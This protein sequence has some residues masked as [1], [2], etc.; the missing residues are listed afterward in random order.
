MQRGYNR[1]VSAGE[2][3]DM[4][5]AQIMEGAPRPG[6]A[7]HFDRS[8]PDP[9]EVHGIDNH[10]YVL[11]SFAKNEGLSNP[12]RG[13]YAFQLSEHGY[14]AFRGGAAADPARN[15]IGDRTTI[16]AVT[17]AQ[18]FNFYIPDPPDINLA[19]LAPAIGPFDAV[20]NNPLPGTVSATPFAERVVLRW[21]ETGRQA[22]H[23]GPAPHQFEFDRTAAPPLSLLTPVDK[24]DQFV[25]TDP[26]PLVDTITMQFLNPD[27]PLALP[28]DVFVNATLATVGGIL[29]VTTAEPHGF[30][31]GDHVFLQRAATGNAAIDAVLNRP[32]GFNVGAFPIPT[33]TTFTTDPSLDATSAL[34]PNVAL[35]N[36][37]VYVPTRRVRI[38]MMLRGMV[39]HLTN[40][41]A[42]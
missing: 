42:P 6:V 4:M 8:V 17:L 33:A 27:L 13:I 29:T 1:Y 18:I 36:L 31:A 3:H 32:E 23:G 7:P 9:G 25:F 41:I 34:T 24:S 26:L 15:R 39:D 20:N 30:A 2:V 21:H 35:G 40:Y 37:D 10:Y 12:A 5:A 22:V 14:A 38:K 16:G 28:R 19:A 11:D